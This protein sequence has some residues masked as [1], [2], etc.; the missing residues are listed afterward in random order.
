MQG[1]EGGKHL[2]G[3]LETDTFTKHRILTGKQKAGLKRKRKPHESLRVCGSQWGM[4][5]WT[6]RCE[7]WFDLLYSMEIAI[8]GCILPI[9]RVLSEQEIFYSSDIIY[10]SERLLFTFNT[11]GPD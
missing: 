7:M 6:E 10:P 8:R 5:G 9:K 11:S 2:F 1:N 3:N 4:N